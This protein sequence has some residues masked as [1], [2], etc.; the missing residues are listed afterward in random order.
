MTLLEERGFNSED[1]R[2]TGN[3]E[4]TTH[5]QAYESY[6][7]FSKN[8]ITAFISYCL[9]ILVKGLIVYRYIG[10]NSFTSI[11]LIVITG[12][13]LISLIRSFINQNDFYKVTGEK[14]G[15]EG[16]LVYFLVGI[17]FYI[18]MYFIFQKQMRERLSYIR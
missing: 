13:F 11:V 1:L 16:A 4:N 15:S 5:T 6:R 7:S 9:A 17:P 18:F 3:L 8:S 14:Y 10:Q 12:I 2:L